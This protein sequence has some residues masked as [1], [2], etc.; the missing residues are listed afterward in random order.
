MP[1]PC[2]GIYFEAWVPSTKKRHNSDVIKMG[3]KDY[4][5]LDSVFLESELIELMQE[6]RHEV[7][8]AS[9]DNY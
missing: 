8:H 5:S 1:C 7:T 3:V 4:Y 2:R 9:A 6:S